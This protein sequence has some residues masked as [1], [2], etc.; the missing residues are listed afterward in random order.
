MGHERVGRLP[1]TQ[2]WRSIVDQIAS[3]QTAD[4]DVSDIAG[5]TIRNVRARFRHVQS[6]G[7]V[8]AA[9]AFL[10]AL[11]ATS[12]SAEPRAA[13][14]DLGI[15]V[16]PNPTPLSLAKALHRWMEPRKES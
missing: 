7:G 12:R 15:E 13:L 14:S 5:Q 4:I 3:F 1:K 6:D 2:R 11:S 9:F 16:P 10:V 8:Q